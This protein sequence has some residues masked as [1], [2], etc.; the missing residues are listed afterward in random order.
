MASSNH[1]TFTGY[2]TAS[3]WLHW[4]TALIVLATVPAGVVMTGENL[5]RA[6]QN[7][8]FIF[9]KNVGVVILLLV[10]LRLV[11][12]AFSTVAPLPDHIPAWQ[13]RAAGVSHA[14]LYALLLVMAI[15]GY[16]RVRAGGFPIEALDAIGVP[17]LVPRSDTVAETAKA[18]HSY[19]R[20]V[21][22]AFIALH[23]G[24]A[25]QHGLVKRDGVF[26][27]I[28]PPNAPR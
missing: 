13:K 20:F 1:T 3:R 23:V 4:I 2:A 9:H 21:L 17:P 25:L 11:V 6:V 15:S 5:S 10:I 14:A 12:R 16:V 27:R 24:A 26:G 8:L 19:A 28:W 7:S 22:V 18:I